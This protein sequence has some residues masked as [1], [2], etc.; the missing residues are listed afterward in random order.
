[1]RILLNNR[2]VISKAVID[3]W[4]SIELSFQTQSDAT[5]KNVRCLADGKAVSK[6]RQFPQNKNMR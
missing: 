4:I 2:K 1:V 5:Y 3:D 6:A